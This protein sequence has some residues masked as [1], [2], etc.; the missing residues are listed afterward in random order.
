[1]FGAFARE[2][3]NRFTRTTVILLRRCLCDASRV[4]LRRKDV[5]RIIRVCLCIMFGRIFPLATKSTCACHMIIVVKRTQVWA[6]EV[7][8][9]LYLCSYNGNRRWRRCWFTGLFRGFRHF[10]R[11]VCS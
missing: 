8:R 9:W 3:C 5:L 7:Y 4:G 11:G 6:F 2:T 1:M 10:L